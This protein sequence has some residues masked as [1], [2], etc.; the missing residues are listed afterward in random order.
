MYQLVN[1]ADELV[2]Q[3]LMLNRFNR[4][5]GELLRG[6]MSRNVFQPWEVE[7]LLDLDTCQIPREAASGCAAS[8]PEGSHQ[9]TRDVLPARPMT[10]SRYLEIRGKGINRLRP[11]D[12]PECE[13]SRCNTIRIASE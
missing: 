9:A 5:I 13:S 4:L 7:L 2:E 6:A 12:G 10:L 3:E 1:P 11:R 8:I